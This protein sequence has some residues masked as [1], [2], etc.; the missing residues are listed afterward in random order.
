MTS[1]FPFPIGVFRPNR[2]GDSK[3]NCPLGEL[4]T[5]KGFF[6]FFFCFCICTAN[7]NADVGGATSLK[8]ETHNN[9]LTLKPLKV[10]LVF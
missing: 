1:H 2:A 3:R 4:N 6:F 5:S 8:C 10:P 9:N 7:V